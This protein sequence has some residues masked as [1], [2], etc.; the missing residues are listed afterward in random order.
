MIK[1]IW[2][3]FVIATPLWLL[4][5]YSTVFAAAA[6]FT[7]KLIVEESLAFYLAFLPYGFVYVSII[8]GSYR[9]L[10]ERLKDE[11]NAEQNDVS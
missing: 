9:E 8:T 10:R 4:I 1:R 2:T 5:V 11:Q 6:F 3:D 7:L